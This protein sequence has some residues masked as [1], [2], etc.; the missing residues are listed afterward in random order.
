MSTILSQWRLIFVGPQ[1]HTSFV[2]PFWRLG[3]LGGFRV[4]GRSVRSWFNL[5]GDR[6]YRLSHMK[7]CNW[8]FFFLDLSLTFYLMYILV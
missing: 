1:Y 3:V 7:R 8:K 4:L 6:R 5:L 2:S